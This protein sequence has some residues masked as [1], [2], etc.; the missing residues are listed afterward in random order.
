MGIIEVRNYEIKKDEREKFDQLF[1]DEL[2]PMLNHWKISV[3]A[4]G[5]SLHDENSY[6]LIRT[7]KNLADRKEQLDNFYNSEEWLTNYDSKVMWF[8]VKYTTTVFSAEQLIN[9]Q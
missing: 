8:I 7:F 5:K 4:F 2:I 3:L 1:Q 6:F 9:R